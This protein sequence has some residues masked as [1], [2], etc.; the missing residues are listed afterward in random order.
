MRIVVA[1]DESRYVETIAKWMTGF[2]H[3]MNTRLTLVHVL[4]P[5]DLPAS[6]GSRSPSDDRS[7]TAIRS[8]GSAGWD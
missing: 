2:P 5:L 3:P 6:P 4:E 7:A 1:L 8:T